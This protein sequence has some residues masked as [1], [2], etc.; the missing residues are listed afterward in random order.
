MNLLDAVRGCRVWDYD[1]DIS[2][3]ASLA[4]ASPQERDGLQATGS[5]LLEGSQD[6]GRFAAR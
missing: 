1:R 5:C 3:L 4:T 2:E 6:V